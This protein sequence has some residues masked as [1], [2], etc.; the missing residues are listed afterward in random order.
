MK[1][2]AILLTLALGAST[3]LLVGQDKNQPPSAQRPPPRAGGPGGEP[4]GETQPL[5]DAQ[6]DQV[7]AILSKYDANTLTAD[8]AKAIHEAFRQTG[9]RGGPTINDAVKAAG[10][11]PEKLREDRKS[12]RLNSSH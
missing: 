8:Q 4:P 3:C 11:N 1:T 9:L 10:F 2:T 7:K 5:T 12:T 6:K